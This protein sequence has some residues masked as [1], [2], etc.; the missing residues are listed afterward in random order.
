MSL[1]GGGS[2]AATMAWE[3]VSLRAAASTKGIRPSRPVRAS[4]L[5]KHILEL[6]LSQSAAFDV[7][8]GAELACHPLAVLL[9]HRRHLL[10]CQLLSDARVVPEINL[11]AD[12]EARDARA[13]VAHL[14]EP[15]LPHVLEAC[16]R[17]DAE[18]DKEDVCLGIREGPQTVIVFLS[19]GIKEPKRVRLVTDP[20]SGSDTV[21]LRFLSERGGV[22]NSVRRLLAELGIECS[23]RE[24]LDAR[25]GCRQPT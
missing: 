17:R 12:Y 20:T 18:A 2:N 21:S 9:P 19:G 16:R 7:L 4:Y 6:V 22:S 25:E 8:Y 10:V 1:C 24:T 13:V 11:G 14:G 15:L 5:V 23:W 3:D